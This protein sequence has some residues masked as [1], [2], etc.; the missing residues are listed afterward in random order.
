MRQISEDGVD[1]YTALESDA[2]R[3]EVSLS[4]MDDAERQKERLVHETLAELR[5]TD[6][7]ADL[8]QARR[9]AEDYFTQADFLERLEAPSGVLRDPQEKMRLKKGFTRPPCRK[10]SSMWERGFS[11]RNGTCES[12]TP[13]PI[14]R[15]S[16]SARSRQAVWTL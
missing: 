13:S 15:R 5:E 4:M 1:D 9:I 12:K 6:E 2:T 14:G 16:L 3:G 11:I 8:A 10:A 7:A